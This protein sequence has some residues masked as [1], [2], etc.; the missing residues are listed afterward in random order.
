MKIESTN[1]GKRVSTEIHLKDNFFLE[2]YTMKRAAGNV[3]SSFVVW[4]KINEN[5]RETAID[6]QPKRIDHGCFSRITQNKLIELHAFALS[7]KEE[8]N[9]LK[10][11]E[12]FNN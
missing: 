4:K 12:K 1:F 10:E 7:Y 8:I 11:L 5:S 6:F 2:I 9:F 3:M